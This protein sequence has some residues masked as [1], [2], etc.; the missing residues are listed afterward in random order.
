[1][2]GE[3]REREERENA[4][5]VA[6]SF[7]SASKA[8]RQYNRPHRQWNSVFFVLSRTESAPEKAPREPD[9][10]QATRDGR[11]GRGEE[12]CPSTKEST[13]AACRDLLRTLRCRRFALAVAL[14]SPSLRGPV[15][16][17]VLSRTLTGRRLRSPARL[18]KRGGCV[19]ERG[20]RVEESELSSVAASRDLFFTFESKSLFGF[21]QSS[22]IFSFF[23]PL[24]F[25]LSLSI[26][27]AGAPLCAL[28]RAGPYA[29]VL[30]RCLPR[31][32]CPGDQ[33][34]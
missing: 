16:G 7:R 27:D 19:R 29:R 30:G 31:S 1:M 2:K 12:H 18:A 8:S 15:P 11:V 21:Q 25:L 22:F 23:S 28:H 20:K 14:P 13:F 24:S 10:R 26:R 5:L 3:R 34:E 4:S 33:S 32:R 17:I 9:W 6:S